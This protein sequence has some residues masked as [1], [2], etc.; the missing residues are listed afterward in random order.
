MAFKGR[1]PTGNRARGRATQRCIAQVQGW[2][3]GA[4]SGVVIGAGEVHGQRAGEG[5]G[6]IIPSH[7]NRNLAPRRSAGTQTKVLRTDYN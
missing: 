4:A 3:P 5:R 6:E 7:L 1:T 2:A